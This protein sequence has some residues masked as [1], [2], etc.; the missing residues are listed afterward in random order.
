MK[1]SRARSAN[2]QF[3]SSESL[4]KDSISSYPGGNRRAHERSERPLVAQDPEEI[5]HVV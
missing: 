3:L 5:P 1:L 4:H 2:L